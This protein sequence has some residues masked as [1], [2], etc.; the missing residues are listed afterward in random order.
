MYC[1]SEIVLSDITVFASDID[2]SHMFVQVIKACERFVHVTLVTITAC[3]SKYSEYIKCT[4]LVLKSLAFFALIMRWSLMSLSILI[5][6][7]SIPFKA[8]PFSQRI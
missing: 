4:V 8:L 1:M 2:L 6:I 5:Y 7:S 3:S